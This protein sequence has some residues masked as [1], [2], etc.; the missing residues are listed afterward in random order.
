MTLPGETKGIGGTC[1]SDC[2]EILPL[3]VCQSAAGYYLGYFCHECGPESRETCY[4]ATFEEA[5]MAL[6]NPTLHLR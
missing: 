6:L 4:F 3:E 1:C 5:A 2:G